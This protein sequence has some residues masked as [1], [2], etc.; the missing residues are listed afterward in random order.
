MKKRKFPRLS[1]TVERSIPV[2]IFVTLTIAPGKTAPVESVMVPLTSPED[3]CDWEKQSTHTRKTS[4]AKQTVR[5]LTGYPLRM[6]KGA[7]IPGRLRSYRN[8]SSNFGNYS[9]VPEFSVSRLNQ[10]R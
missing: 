1:D 4:A 9:T 7:R 2:S 6:L 5:K 3:V 10:V 8:C